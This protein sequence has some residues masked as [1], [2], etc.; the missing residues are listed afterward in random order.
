VGVPQLGEDDA[1]RERVSS[2]HVARWQER[3][4]SE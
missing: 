1:E 2:V 4:K 3:R